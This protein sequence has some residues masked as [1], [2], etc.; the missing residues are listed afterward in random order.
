MLKK[1]E[2]KIPTADDFYVTA[3]RDLHDKA[4]EYGYAENGMIHVADLT[5]YGQKFLLQMLN[6][7]IFQSKFGLDAVGY[8]FNIACYAFC[9]G[10]YYGDIWQKNPDLLKKDDRLEFLAG[11]DVYGLAVEI[12]AIEETA[13]FDEFLN[14]L[15]D[16]WLEIM[17]PYWD[18]WDS[19]EYIFRGLLIFYQIGISERLKDLGR[20]N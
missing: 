1:Y 11:N 2:K 15:F 20:Q 16:D 8:Y 6:D 7:K 5:E 18:M 3:L 12:L 4:S 14:K 9:G 10:V 13:V 17:D 19:R